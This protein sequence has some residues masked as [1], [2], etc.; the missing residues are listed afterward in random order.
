MLSTFC[1]VKRRLLSIAY[2][3]RAAPILAPKGPLTTPD[4][5][6]Q[7]HCPP[8]QCSGYEL[9]RLRSARREAQGGSNGLLCDVHIYLQ[10][11]SRGFPG[12]SI[13]Y[14]LHWDWLTRQGPVAISWDCTSLSFTSVVQHDRTQG[15][16]QAPRPETIRAEPCCYPACSFSTD[17]RSNRSIFICCNEDTGTCFGLWQTFFEP[18]WNQIASF[19]P[20]N[21]QLALVD[22]KMRASRRKMLSSPSTN[23]WKMRCAWI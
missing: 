9:V 6:L 20:S 19:E 12:Q 4:S 1:T 17:S 3:L 21:P 5:V 23:S 14:K 7:S 8:A 13:A 22:I 18:L 2:S 16:H 15:L 10:V 11:A